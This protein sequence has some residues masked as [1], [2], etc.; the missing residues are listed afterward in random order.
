MR[1]YN[2]IFFLFFFAHFS[3]LT[4]MRAYNIIAIT[5]FSD[6]SVYEGFIL[7]EKEI[8]MLKLRR[9]ITAARIFQFLFYALGFP[10]I[11]H[12]VLV[13]SGPLIDNGL[14]NSGEEQLIGTIN[15][16]TGPAVMGIYYG[17]ALWAIFI[18]GQL[19]LK[20]FVRKNRWTRTAIAVILAAIIIVGPVLYIDL[21]KKPEYDALQASF[22]ERNIEVEDWG[23]SASKFGEFTEDN[24]ADI[25]SFMRTYNIQKFKGKNYSD[26]NADGS[27]S[28]ENEEDAA[29]YSPNGMYADGYVFSFK[30]AN[31]VL[32]DYYTNKAA[33]EADGENIEIELQQALEEL[34]S[35]PYSDWS[36]YKRGDAESSFSMED[37]SYIT[38]SDEYEVAYGEDGIARKYYLTEERLAQVL[39]VL[40][41]ELGENESI[42]SLLP[43]ISSFIDLGG[44]DIMSL[45][46]EDLS[47]EVLVDVVNG[48]G[49]GGTLRQ[50]VDPTSTE[51]EIDEAF[52]FGL[53]ANYSSYQSPMTYPVFYFIEDEGLRDFAYANYYAKIHGAKIGSVLVGTGENPKVGHITMD[54]SGMPAPTQEEVLATI[55]QFEAFETISQK[56][57]PLFALR[58]SLVKFGAFATLCVFAAYALTIYIDKKYAKLT[59]KA[60][61]K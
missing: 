37:F 16:Y 31:K 14:V 5:C 23:K 2:I 19:L 22:A 55:D 43:A 11:V 30:Q 38:D 17:L 33:Y 15:Y 49:L 28:I 1:P 10:L 53:L 20:L 50:L 39:S 47:L 29:W 42:G 57:Y 25:D 51:T 59:L 12:L 24:Q 56:F 3:M 45:L 52:V 60:G 58:E 34:E 27:L 61:V 4:H 44:L 40:G 21:L 7:L 26:T 6:F 32:K 9:N 46:N 35:N 48:L 36:R 13:S 54:A 18:L 41:R 8:S